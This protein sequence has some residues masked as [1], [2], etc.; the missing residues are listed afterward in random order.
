MQ[1]IDLL[2]SP[3]QATDLD[4]LRAAFPWIDRHDPADL[5]QGLEILQRTCS[6]V[7]V[8][9]PLSKAEPDFSVLPPSAFD[10]ARWLFSGETDPTA[11]RQALVGAGGDSLA[12]AL[13]AQGQP[14][15]PANRAS[16][17]AWMKSVARKP[18]ELGQVE[19]KVATGDEPAASEV[20]EAAKS[21]SLRRSAGDAILASGPSGHW[22][23]RRT[24][25]A[26]KGAAF[27]EVAR[28]WGIGHFVPPACALS[29]DGAAYLAERP[30]AKRFTALDCRDGRNASRLALVAPL[31]D[32]TLHRLAVLDYVLGNADRHGSTVM[33]DD[34]GAIL[35]TR[36]DRCL[37]ENF[38]PRDPGTFKPAYMASW[39]EWPSPGKATDAVGAW[40]VGLRDEVLRSACAGRGLNFAPCLERL[41]RLQAEAKVGVGEAIRRAW[42]GAATQ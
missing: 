2:G 20:G 13:A 39:G 22:I 34:K 18:A 23:L 35:L 30:A 38:D 28:S 14:N 36:N 7:L 10:A 32:G 42:L 6:S 5:A 26:P 17:V 37:A 27:W 3:V 29:L 21:G 19:F 15:T 11:E 24:D 33:V 16:L 1:V 31:S 8:L 12:A 9:A 4:S 41:R 25:G 40:L